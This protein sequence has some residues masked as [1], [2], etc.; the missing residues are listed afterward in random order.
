MFSIQEVE[1]IL[2]NIGNKKE[3]RDKC[4]TNGCYICLSESCFKVEIPGEEDLIL[5][6][7]ELTSDHEIGLYSIYILYDNNNN[8][9]NSL[10]GVGLRAFLEKMF[11]YKYKVLEFTEV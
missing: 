11:K 1:N 9:I 5:F 4:C 2:E 7:G 6:G 10:S 3:Y 8:I